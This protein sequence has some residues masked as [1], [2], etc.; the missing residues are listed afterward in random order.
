MN[1]DWIKKICE[2]SGISNTV[3]EEIKLLAEEIRRLEQKIIQLES[4]DVSTGYAKAVAEEMPK[5][6]KKNESKNKKNH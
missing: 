5:E 1:N 4:V 2:R 3:R 6:K